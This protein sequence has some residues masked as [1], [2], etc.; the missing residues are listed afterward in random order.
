MQ[1]FVGIDVSSKKLNIHILHSNED[2]EIPNTVESI[3]TFTREQN[4]IK[5]ST[6]IG[7]ES[8][9]RYHLIA[10][11]T[12]VK[13]GYTFRVLNPILTNKKIKLSVR[14]KKTD[15]S[16]AKLIAQLISQGEG[17]EIKENELDK[18]RRTILR[19]RSTLVKYKASLKVLL[20][21]LKRDPNSSQLGHCVN[22]IMSTV[23]QLEESVKQ[24]EENVL[25]ESKVTKNE[26]L[27]QS[28]PGFATKLSAI[29][30]SEV[31]EFS[32]FPSSNEFK[33][34]VG[35]DP[36]VKQSGNSMFTGKITKRGNPHL[37]SAFYLAAQVARIH[38]PELKAFYE[39][40]KSE[41]K[42]TRVAIVAVAR[43]L[44]ERVYAIIKK[45]TPYQ[46]KSYEISFV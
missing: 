33:A 17:A 41:G 39:K 11:N 28:I 37:R 19:T 1:K 8:T 36:K 32:R 2:F 24:L 5:D 18:T 27:I 9:G 44:C 30:V 12:F 25:D 20:G 31:G 29:V 34:F 4:L 38:D 23:R 6:V 26:I 45:G 46:I 16:D 7:C 15:I 14:K 43:K 22:V 21:E 10:E 13:L 3:K 42:P 40:K 35:V